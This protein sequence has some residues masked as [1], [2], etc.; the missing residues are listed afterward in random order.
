MFGMLCGTEVVEWLSA[1]RAECIGPFGRSRGKRLGQTGLTRVGMSELTPAWVKD[2]M[3]EGRAV[4]EDFS[5][6]A[7]G[8]SAPLALTDPLTPLATE[9]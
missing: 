6:R 1:Q 4:Y 3:T 5:F 9:E 7:L 8:E 2:G